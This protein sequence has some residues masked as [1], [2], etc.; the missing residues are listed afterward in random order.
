MM[1]FCASKSQRFSDV[2]HREQICLS[3]G[4]VLSG[5]IS[6]GWNEEWKDDCIKLLHCAM[7]DLV[8]AS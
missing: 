7:A 2:T 4:C 5:G 3:R 1:S 6:W 8:I